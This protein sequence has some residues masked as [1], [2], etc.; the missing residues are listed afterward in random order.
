MSKVST[1]SKT[2]SSNN[3]ESPDGFKEGMLPSGLNDSAREVMAQIRTERENAQW[4]DW[5]DTPT[6]VDAD[7]FTLTGDQTAEYHVGRRVRITDAS[8]L[9]G[10]I[11]ASAYTS[12]TTID[13]TLDSG[14]ITASISAVELGVLSEDNDSLPDKVI[15][16]TG[17][18]ISDDIPMAATKGI[19]FSA[20]TS[21]AGM[22]SEV[23]DWY[24]EGTWTPVLVDSSYS[25]SEGQTYTT[26]SAR[27]TRIG[28]IVFI[29]CTIQMSSLGTLTTSDAAIIKGLP[30]SRTGGSDTVLSCRGFNLSI[31]AGVTV[32][33][34]MATSENIGLKKWASAAGS[35]DMT[36]GEV[37]ASGQLYLSGHYLV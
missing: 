9:Y 28:R 3:A 21:A 4:F 6:F 31:T 19:D 10:T 17:S 14:S 5:G 35:V 24:E 23:L 18:T 30:Y 32:V 34:I 11:S 29:D 12:L 13:V 8:T 7:T 33:G 16:K 1:W 20:N 2:A 22:T 37:T 25:T 36:I 26:Q 15:K 27:Y